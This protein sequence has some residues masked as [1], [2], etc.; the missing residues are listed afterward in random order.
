ME[1]SDSK[2]RAKPKDPNRKA[3]QTAKRQDQPPMKRGEPTAAPS[4]LSDGA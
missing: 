2:D 4:D 3:A 1:Y